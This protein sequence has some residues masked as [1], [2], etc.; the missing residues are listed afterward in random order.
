MSKKYPN[1][2]ISKENLEKAVEFGATPT[3]RK[4]AAQLLA[5]ADWT[6]EEEEAFKTIEET[7][8]STNK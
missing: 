1:T 2:T 6:I 3:I 7:Q 4:I 8:A 5:E